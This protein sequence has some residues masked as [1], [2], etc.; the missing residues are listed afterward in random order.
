MKRIFFLLQVNGD[1]FEKLASLITTVKLI[2]YIN[3]ENN[4][5]AKKKNQQESRRSFFLSFFFFKE[6]CHN[7]HMHLQFEYV[8]VVVIK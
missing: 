4:L 2:L 3:L 5:F 8:T 6:P 7:K 1:Q